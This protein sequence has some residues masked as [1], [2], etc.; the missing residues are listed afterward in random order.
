MEKWKEVQSASGERNITI[1]W[2]NKMDKVE[3][4][5]QCLACQWNKMCAEPPA[6]TEEE[7][8]AKISLGEETVGEKRIS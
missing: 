1:I 3:M 6:M 4:Q 7:V 5:T 2:R 8:L